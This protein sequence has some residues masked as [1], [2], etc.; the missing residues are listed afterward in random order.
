MG[1]PMP[2]E[3]VAFAGKAVKQISQQQ[4]SESILKAKELFEIY[5]LNALYSNG[6]AWRCVELPL[7]GQ[8]GVMLAA[9]YDS[10]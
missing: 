3:K 9:L 7:E 2:C 6:L 4:S 5:K 8:V 1:T 10:V